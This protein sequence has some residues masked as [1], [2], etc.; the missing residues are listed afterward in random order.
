MERETLTT[1]EVALRD[2]LAHSLETDPIAPEEIIEV[3][4][5]GRKHPRFEAMLARIAANPSA[6]ALY[7]AA[8]STRPKSA[9]VKKA[10]EWYENLLQLPK[11]FEDVIASVQRTPAP[12]Y[13]SGIA[14][15]PPRLIAPDP[16]NQSVLPGTQD[17]K[18]VADEADVSIDQA[19]KALAPVDPLAP[20]ATVTVTV[21]GED[22][23]SL[24]GDQ[25]FRFRVLDAA[26]ADRVRWAES[27]AETAPVAAALTLFSL[28][29]FADAERLIARWPNDPDLAAWASL[30][31]LSCE[32]RRMDA[33][34][35]F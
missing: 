12:A 7:R 4:E 5:R 16:G 8:R 20:G 24:E 34:E 27:N 19:G 2:T 10:E 21:D 32:A 30:I 14:Q 18:F 28:G 22:A 3:A 29:R 33:R 31:R 11:W 9:L 25:V 35:L 23:W 13:R 26:E 15:A 17:W 6:L 1:T